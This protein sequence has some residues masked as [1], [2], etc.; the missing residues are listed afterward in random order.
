MNADWKGVFPAV[1]TQFRED[2]SLDL[3]LTAA[4]IERL[5]GSGVTGL[6]MLGS[7]GENV[8]LTLEEKR[9]VMRMTIDVANGRVPVLSGVAELSTAA[10]VAWVQEVEKLGAQGAMVMPCMAFR[11]DREETMAHYSTV[12]TSTSLP[13]IVYN[14]PISYHA[15]IVPDMFAE[16]A[17]YENLVAI[18]ESSGDVRRMTDIFNVVGDRYTIFA[19]VDDLALESVLLG[20]KGWIAGVGL[21]FP[22]ENQRLWELATSGQWDA[23][24][25]LYR[26][27]TPL[28]HLDVGL[29][30]VQNIKLLLQEVGLGTEYVRLPRLAL[31]GAERER[32]LGVIH[33]GLETRPTLD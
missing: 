5:I 27:Y 23:A 19:G 20:A 24:R 28:L 17:K 11:P 29:K 7:L 10:A 30:F 6:V 18:K 9:E 25:A 31:S 8:A 4:H 13:L 26:W 15:D 16:L 21:A 14:N 1:T 12:A 32:V 33:K 3:D 2:L 22:E